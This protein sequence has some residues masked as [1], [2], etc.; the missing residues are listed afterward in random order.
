LN[1]S[2]SE[3][4]GTLLDEVG[5]EVAGVEYVKTSA[6]EAGK[7]GDASYSYLNLSIKLLVC[8]GVEVGGT[9]V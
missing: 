7:I 3:N 9:L 5:D 8:E 2:D 4:V 6:I 1:Y